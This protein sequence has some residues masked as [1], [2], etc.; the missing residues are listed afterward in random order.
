MIK[1]DKM[2]ERNREQ[3]NRNIDNLIKAALYPNV[4]PSREL[5]DTIIQQAL[6][7][8]NIRD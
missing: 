3:Q 8:E 1:S 4:E 2:T 7:E 5:N 6:R